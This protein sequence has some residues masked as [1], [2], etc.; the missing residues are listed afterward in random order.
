[1]PLKRCTNAEGKK[2][3]AWGNGGCQ[4][5]ATDE[6]S[7]KQAIRVGLKVDGPK[8]FSEIMKKDKAAFVD[9]DGLRLARAVYKEEYPRG[10]TDE[11]MVGITAFF[12]DE[13]A[14]V[15]GPTPVGPAFG[16][17]EEDAEGS[18]VN[19]PT[20][21]NPG[22]A[23]DDDESAEGGGVSEQLTY[24]AL[25]NTDRQE[26]SNVVIPSYNEDA[27]PESNPKDEDKTLVT[28]TVDEMKGT[29]AESFK[30]DEEE[31]PVEAALA[32]REF[33]DYISVAFISTDTRNHLPHDDFGDP[34]RKAY[35]V[36]DQSDLVNAFRLLHFS[37]KP[38][39]VKKNLI[40]IARQKNLKLPSHMTHDE[41][42]VM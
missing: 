18:S 38:S 25:D 31:G 17:D 10:Y 1:M 20:P 39:E 8:K 13:A 28:P 37:D 21:V 23:S 42:C 33:L 11:F 15:N 34:M 2:G 30:D 9:F 35:P 3:W 24:S 4:V 36:R 32:E 14:G 26:F 12:K 29:Q 40:R 5:A 41:G 6:E 19:N 16:D 27:S 7:K 22:F